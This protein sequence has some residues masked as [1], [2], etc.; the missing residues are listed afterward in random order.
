MKCLCKAIC[1]D[2]E[3]EFVPVSND[4]TCMTEEEFYA[5]IEHSLEQA[6]NG[7]VQTLDM[8]KL[9]EFLGL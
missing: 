5:K 4:D 6:R 3:N 2:Q 8:N 1:L 7:K 9:D